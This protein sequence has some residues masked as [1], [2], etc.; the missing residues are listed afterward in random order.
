M[1][2][3]DSTD[4]QLIAKSL[5]GNQ[6]AIEAIYARYAQS[7]YRYGFYQLGDES[8]AND[9]MQD[10]FVEMIHSLKSFSFNGQF[11]NWLYT[12]AKRQVLNKIKEKYKY[13]KTILGDWLPAKEDP[14]WIDN[15][16]QENKKNKLVK[17]LLQKLNSEERKA[18]KLVYF[19]NLSSKEAGIVTGRTPES[20][21]VLVHRAI[22]K[23]AQ[24]G[25]YA[26]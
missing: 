26:R 17:Q 9:I 8:Q 19:Q 7:I 23:M 15:I 24:K 20:I 2:P 18:I 1:L 21:R 10:T 22:K 11:K 12:I 13:P 25:T 3:R 14:N 4:E 5:Q 16:E 6:K